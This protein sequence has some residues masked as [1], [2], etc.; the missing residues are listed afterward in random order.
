M[1][2]YDYDKDNR[3]G[4]KHGQD[5]MKLMMHS[6]RRSNPFSVIRPRKPEDRKRITANSWMELSGSCTPGLPGVIFRNTTVHGKQ[7]T[8]G[9]L[10]GRKAKNSSSCLKVF[11]RIR[12][13]RICVL[14]T[15][16][17]CI[18]SPIDDFRKLPNPSE[19]AHLGLFRKDK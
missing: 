11:A 5:D 4:H 14:M 6:G 19:L 1:Y 8:N 15:A 3:G 18:I 2:N 9:F 16:L 13:C 10:S 7:C 17:A 12:T